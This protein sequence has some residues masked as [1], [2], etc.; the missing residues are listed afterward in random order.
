M[1][2]AEF[3][4]LKSRDPG[5]QKLCRQIFKLRSAELSWDVIYQHSDWLVVEPPTRKIW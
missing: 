1:L 4:H 5:T 3:Q 2:D